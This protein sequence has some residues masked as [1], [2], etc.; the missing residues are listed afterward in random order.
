MDIYKKYANVIYNIA[1]EIEPI[2]D[3]RFEGNDLLQKTELVFAQKVNS[4]N[5]IIVN[6]GTMG[7]YACLLAYNIEEGCEILLPVN[8]C[9]SI[10]NV[11]IERR[12]IPIFV[13]I[14]SNLCMKIEDL[15]RKITLNTKMVIFVHSYGFPMR[16]DEIIQYCRLRGII[17]V[18]D[19][20]QAPFSMLNGVRVGKL[21]D[22]AI[23]SFGQNKPI[24]AGGGGMVC[25]SQKEDAMRIRI[26]AREGAINYPE[27]LDLGM[28]LS[29]NNLHALLLYYWLINIES[30]MAARDERIRKYHEVFE[31]HVEYIGKLKDITYGNYNMFHK[32][33]LKMPYLLNKEKYDCFFEKLYKDNAL[34]RQLVQ[35]SLVQLPYKV[36]YV[37]E[38]WKK[39]GRFDLVQNMYI[40]SERVQNTYIYMSTHHLITLDMIEH[41]GSDIKKL[42]NENSAIKKK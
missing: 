37:R 27:F 14:D 15:K 39:M 7:L 31:G 21:G 1:K 12:L 6:S 29:I 22:V 4:N 36:N 8:I 5:P 20:A 19:C 24:S 28:C 35:P 42:L 41:V 26:A 2:L 18:E 32:F 25:A 11:I 3:Y 16:L 23:Y 40:G 13:D 34:A 10:V 9:Q 33:I 38:Y 30:I 17:C